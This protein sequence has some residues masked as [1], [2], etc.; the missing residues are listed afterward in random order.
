MLGLVA[1]VVLAGAAGGALA[2]YLNNGAP[3]AVSSLLHSKVLGSLGA[4]SNRK[5]STAAIAARVEASVVDVNVNLAYGQGQAEGT[6]MILT[7]SGRILTNNHVVQGA[8][9]ITVDVPHRGSF[10]ARV[11]G[12]DPKDDVAVLQLLNAPSNLPVMPFGNSSTMQIGNKVVA[13]GNALGLGG[14]PSVTSGAITALGRAI[15]ASND[16]GGSEHLTN[17]LQTSA[18]LQ[19]GDSGGPLL[20]SSAQVIGMDTAAETSSGVGYFPNGSSNTAPSAVAFSIPINRALRIANEIVKGDVSAT[21]VRTR[22]AFL[23]VEVSN[24]SS[25]PPYVQQQ[26]ATTTGAVVIGALP[27]TPAYRAGIGQYDVLTAIDG[28]KVT[29]I[30]QLGQLIKDHAPG[31]QIT[32]EWEG[33]GGHTHT[34]TVTLTTAPIA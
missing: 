30:T 6:G 3:S 5:L 19:P 18:P 27:G 11:I 10:K 20:N 17:M 16:A 21:I 7:A 12:V 15:T 33:T 29:N 13:I 25:L 2:T 4:T 23:G 14:P 28:Q 22:S 8:G 26:L 32:V 31:S 1:L 9:T 34:A 24:A